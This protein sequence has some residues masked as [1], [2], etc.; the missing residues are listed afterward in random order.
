[1][2]REKQKMFF[3]VEIL[4]GHLLGQLVLNKRQD[5]FSL[6]HGAYDCIVAIFVNLDHYRSETVPADNLYNLQY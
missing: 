4:T 5:L 3:L 6:S 1:M 2:I